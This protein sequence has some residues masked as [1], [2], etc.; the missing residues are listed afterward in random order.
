[1]MRIAAAIIAGGKATR[2][3]G[4]AKG[5][6]RDTHGLTIIQR[7]LE[8]IAA[9]GISEVV[10]SA[11]DRRPYAELKLP[12]I[13]DRHLDIGPLG[14]IEAVLSCLAPQ[15]DCVL[16]LPCDL[17]NIAAED[18]LRLVSSYE[19]VGPGRIAFARTA[20][21]DHPL[22][23]IAPVTVLPAVQAAIADGEYGVIRLWRSL[24]ARPVD[25]DDNSRMMNLNTPEDVRA[26]QG[27][28]QTPK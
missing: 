26:W 8:Q 14:G 13:A 25:F 17:P 21:S 19:I 1:M 5:M 28:S 22:C 2:L 23:A 18:I 16:L 24:N 4:V 20:M 6:L 15:C 11:N 12:I 3:G 27:S 10:I 7:L 9:A